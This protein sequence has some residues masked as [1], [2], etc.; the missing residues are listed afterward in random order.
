MNKFEHI[1]IIHIP[2]GK[3]ASADALAKLVA[4]LVLPDGEP[5]QIK[6]EERWLL[7]AVLEL[8]PEEYEVD[9]VL[10]MAVEADDWY[11]PFLDYFNHGTLSN[12]PVER[13]HLQQR[14]PSYIQK[15]RVL[16]RLSFGHE[17][18]LRCVS[19]KEADQILLE[20]HKGVCGGHQS[21]AK[22]YHSIKLVGYYWPRIMSDCLKI[23][24]SCHNCQIHDNF[25][26]LPPVPLHPTVPTCPFD[27]WG[28][29]VIDAI[30]PLS[31]R[32]HHFILAT[33]DY[34]SK[35]VEAIPLREV[36]SNNVINFLERHI[37]YRFGVPRRIT[38]DNAKAFKSNK[39]HR[40]IVKY[41]ITCNYSTGYYSQAN[42]LAEAFN[43]TLGKIIKKTATKN[44][45]DWHDRLFEALWAY[46]VTVCTPTQAT[47]YSLVYMSEAVLPLEVQLP[48]LRVAVHEEITKDEQIQL[49]FQELD[50]LEESRL[51]AIQNLELYRQNMVRVYDKLVKQ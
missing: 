33:T 35:W 26:H 22:M 23:A 41:N 2:R 17:I 16:Y 25:K 31:A 36:K 45:R 34:F 43:K 20:M 30:E 42:S 50:A 8:V 46:R 5:A 29:D 1:N 37:I 38:S 7:P 15:A 49:R 3:N 12:D 18:L 39:M 21:G 48:S 13:R 11:K 10:V 40:F 32:G 28:I 51:Q 19:W 44:R 47:P 4:A 9:H 27:A 14:L 6:I 24:K